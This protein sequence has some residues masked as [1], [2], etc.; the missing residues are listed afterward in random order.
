MSEI[1]NE[2]I[3]NTQEEA[4]CDEIKKQLDNLYNTFVEPLGDIIVHPITF[5]V[6]IMLTVYL[7]LQDPSATLSG[8]IGNSILGIFIM[9]IYVVNILHHIFEVNIVEIL[10]AVVKY[11]FFLLK[12][13]KE[14]IIKLL[15]II[16]CL[17]GLDFHNLFGDSKCSKSETN[18]GSQP[19]Q[20]VQEKMSDEEVFHIPGNHYTYNEAANMCEAHGARLATYD[21]MEE[22]YNEGAEWCS[23]GW[24]QGQMAFFPTQKATFNELQKDPKRKNDCGRPGV[25]GG[26]M[27]NPYIKFGVNCYGVKPEKTENDKMCKLAP[28]EEKK[29]SVALSGFNQDTWS[30]YERV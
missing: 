10:Q 22:A 14:L 9:F 1:Q 13:L 19:Q 8:F 16:F 27:A 28:V 21:Q 11:I 6:N 25:N 15:E 3:G 30:R 5:L 24:S 18:V 23:Y 17:F 26:Y 20:P 12:N 4:P 7:Y 29:P 2:N